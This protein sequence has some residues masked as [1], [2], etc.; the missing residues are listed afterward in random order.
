MNSWDR[1]PYVVPAGFRQPNLMSRNFLVAGGGANGG[2]FDTDDGSS[3]YEFFENVEIYGG[4]KSDF[5]GHSKRCVTV[6]LMSWDCAS[7]QLD[8]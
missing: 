4:H 7:R 3:F 6:R 8:R 1:V 2:A 5:D